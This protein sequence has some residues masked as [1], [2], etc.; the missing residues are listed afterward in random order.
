MRLRKPVHFKVLC[1]ILPI[2]PTTAWRRVTA[3][4][5][6]GFIKTVD[7][8]LI[9]DSKWLNN[10]SLI[11]NACDRIDRMHS[12]ISR[13][14]SSGIPLNHIKNLYIRGRSTPLAL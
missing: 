14:A 10:S 13:M 11:A 7:G 8:G 12:I 4:K 5:I 9:V 6:L 2:C 3:M 1:E